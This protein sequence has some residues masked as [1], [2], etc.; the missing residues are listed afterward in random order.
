MDN[1]T[2]YSLL[3]YLFLLLTVFIIFTFTKSFYADIVENKD[4]IRILNEQIKT[5]SEE[6]DKIAKIKS[7]IESWTVKD[8]NFDKFLVNFSEDELLEYFYSYSNNHVNN[9]KIESLNLSEWKLNEFW[10]NE[11]KIELQAT[12]NSEQDMIDMINFLLK[13]EKYNLYIHDFTYPFWSDSKLPL[14]VKIPLKVLYINK[15]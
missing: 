15:N 9:L 4:K 6:Y 13:S 1:K 3:T 12:F 11:A 7:Q 2:K 14:K 8:I 5:K 10:F